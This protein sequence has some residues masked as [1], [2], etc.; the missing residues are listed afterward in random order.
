VKRLAGTL[1]IAA[2]VLIPSLLFLGRYA[3]EGTGVAPAGSDTPQHVWRSAVVAR[4]G[5]DALPPYEGDAHALL[6]NADRPG[7]PLVFAALGASIDEEPRDLVY[8]LPAV[9]AA[10]IASAA[11]AL[12]AS[13]PR[14]P[15]WGAALAGLATGASVQV[16]L[17]ANGYLDQL[18]VEPLLLAAGVGAL[19]AAAGDPGRALC[20][21][22]LVAAS[23]VHWQFAALFAGLLLLVALACLPESL[24]GRGGSFLDSPSG[25]LG[26]AVGA[27][28]GLGIA[29]LL[30]GAPGAPRSPSAFAR[31][32]TA[33]REQA[34]LYRL[35]GAVLAA[36]VGIASL[37]SPPAEAGRRRAGWLLGPWALLPAGAALLY[38]AG[39]AVPVQRTLSFALA[40]PLLGGL[41]AAAAVG[42]VR[43]RAGRLLAVAAALVVAAA[44]L[45]SVSFGWDVWRSR[46][47]WSEDRRLAELQT[48]ARYLA[49]T[50][51]PAVLVVDVTPLGATRSHGELGTVPVLR[52][53]RAELPPSLVLGTTV[54]LGD[55]DL[56]AEGRPTLRPDIPGFDEISRET[57]RAV[58]P[59]LARE[60]VIVILRSRFEGFGAAVRDHPG[61]SA[62]GWMAV[63][64]GPP[65]PPGRP[66]VPARPSPASLVTWWAASLGVVTFAGAG[67]AGRLS[68]G[69]PGLAI[70]LAPAVGLASL[71]VAGTVAERIGIRMGG[72]GGVLIVIVVALVGAAAAVTRPPRAG[73]I[74]LGH[75]RKLATEASRPKGAVGP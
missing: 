65:A 74:A 18:L 51:G 21:G 58:R 75:R 33:D 27:G 42:W 22:C 64:E 48:L 39:R 45:G 5:L 28:A 29:A 14:V 36:A 35:P 3:I 60:P 46:R 43:D 34:R 70:G 40:I 12:A 69:S 4:F 56:L 26:T 13:I 7:L 52:R 6:T 54:Y 2:V 68:G 17:A 53:I 1:S 61:W 47:P 72:A 31:G 16:A 19:R 63:V 44:V 37:L 55:P 11:A 9:L 25:R 57:W 73:G 15:W 67:W 30:I 49:A 38:A 71:I 66:I 10:A 59:L 62:N 24:G 32:A 50:G 41:G 20:A 8:V 23:L